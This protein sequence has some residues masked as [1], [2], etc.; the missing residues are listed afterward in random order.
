MEDFDSPSWLRNALKKMRG[1]PRRKKSDQSP[2]PVFSEKLPNS[3]TYNWRVIGRSIRGASHLRSGLPNQDAIGWVPESGTGSEL[4]IAVSDGHGSAKYFRSDVGAAFAVQA[5][6][7]EGQNLISGQPDFNLSAIKRTAEERLP[8][9]IVRHWERLVQ[10]HVASNPIS[11]EELDQAIAK[12]TSPVDR[13]TLEANP[14]IC[15]GATILTAVVTNS[16]AV[17]LRLGDGD[18]LTV[19]EGEE[20]TRPI[21][22][23]AK[24]ESIG[25]DTFSLCLPNVWRDFAFSFQALSGSAPALILVTTD[26]YPKSFTDDAG[27]LK[28]GSDIFEL[29]RTEG[30]DAVNEN[31]ESWLNEASNSGSGDDIT[32][33]LI[34][35]GEHS[36]TASKSEIQPEDQT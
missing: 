20:V 29:I 26:G 9:A 1:S 13:N 16:F 17:F 18:I 3:P 28:L 33:G 5:A 30:L 7:A 32:L 15:Y 8:Q 10:E 19:F 22:R 34:Y 21:P 6:L 36:T 12:S 4:I 2:E 31:L 24:E 25:D 23:L 11:A 14:L 35:R 27:F